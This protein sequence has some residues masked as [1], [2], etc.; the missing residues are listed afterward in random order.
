MPVSPTNIQSPSNWS[1][2]I[3]GGNSNNGYAVQWL[4]SSSTTPNPLTPGSSFSFVFDSTATPS[5]LAGNSSFYPN[6]PTGTSFVYTGAPFSDPGFKFVATSVVPEPSAWTALVLG[7]GG[8]WH[9]GVAPP[10]GVRITSWR[11]RRDGTRVAQPLLWFLV[12]NRLQSVAIRVEDKSGEVSRAILRTKCGRAV[13]TGPR[14]PK[15]RRES[16][17]AASR[18]GAAKAKCVPC[19]GTA[20]KQDWALIANLSPPPGRARSRPHRLL[21]TPAHIRAGPGLRRRRRPSASDRT[22][23]RTSD[24]AW[25]KLGEIKLSGGDRQIKDGIPSGWHRLIADARGLLVASTI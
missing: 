1:A 15:P 18:E 3:T 19:P 22:L 21:S 8:R 9:H 4:T 11:W 2:N 20:T 6:T 5:S 14:G 17:R 12:E 23:P 25:K 7:V 24:E 13:V 10:T 16:G